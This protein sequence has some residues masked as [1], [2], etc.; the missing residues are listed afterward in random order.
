MKNY[1]AFTRF[2]VDEWED[3]IEWKA[4]RLSFLWDIRK[5]YFEL[6]L[7]N[8]LNKELQDDFYG[9][10]NDQVSNLAAGISSGTYTKDSKKWAKLDISFLYEKYI[11]LK[12]MKKR[13]AKMF[14]RR[15]NQ[16]LYTYILERRYEE[17]S[18]YIHYNGLDW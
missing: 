15:N 12:R 11:E 2:F 13:D 6:Y 1:R 5:F 8:N 4:Q 18:D 3:D 10:N 7:K 16:F 9:I 14:L 17:L